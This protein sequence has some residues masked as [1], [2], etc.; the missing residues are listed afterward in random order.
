MSA[1]EA[2]MCLCN[3]KAVVYCVTV[4]TAVQDFSFHVAVT[5]ISV[6][7]YIELHN[8]LYRSIAQLILFMLDVT[9]SALNHA[10]L[11]ASNFC[12]SFLSSS[13]E[14]ET[15]S[16]GISILGASAIQVILTTLSV[17]FL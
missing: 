16:H 7:T 17:R 9:S 14:S 13:S 2:E 8:R 3:S 10:L 6:Y 11:Y 1:L 12:D 5:L 4:E 15:I